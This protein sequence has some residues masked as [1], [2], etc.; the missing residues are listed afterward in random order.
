VAGLAPLEQIAAA[1]GMD[2]GEIAK[3][4]NQLEAAA[5]WYCLNRW[6]PT[7]T[8]PFKLRKK[9]DRVAKSAGRLFESLGVNDPDEACDG[10]GDPE[11][12][13]ARVLAGESEDP[14][15]RV[16]ILS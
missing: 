14:V 4:Q 1:I 7:R 5:L 6:R 2:V 11:I 13:R 16:R 15:I 12:L 9:L 3:H 10:P 8:A